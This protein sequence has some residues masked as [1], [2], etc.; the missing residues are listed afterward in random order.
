M[1]SLIDGVRL[2]PLVFTKPSRT[3]QSFRDECDINTIMKKY[4]ATGLVSH[5][6]KYGGQYGDFT[7]FGDY[8]ESLNIIIDAQSMFMSLPAK[9]RSRFSND[10]AVFLDF[11]GNPSNRD[12][13][14]S[15]GLVKAVPVV[16]TPVAVPA[17]DKARKKSEDSD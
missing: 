13:M 6:K 4:A 10:P 7:E 16:E 8:Q 15:L 9:L 12:E 11:V 3:K 17:S 5:V 14:V 1:G 2:H